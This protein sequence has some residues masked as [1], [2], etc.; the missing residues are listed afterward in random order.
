ME[1]LSFLHCCIVLGGIFF[2]GIILH[3]ALN[4]FF[5]PKCALCKQTQ[6]VANFW[7]TMEHQRGGNKNLPTVVEE[8]ASIDEDI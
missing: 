4:Y 3:I 7:D 8:D 6:T 5:P 1:S 2:F